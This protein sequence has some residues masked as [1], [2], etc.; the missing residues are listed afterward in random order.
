MQK[1]K[2][3]ILF[4]L[5]HFFFLTHAQD[6][7]NFTQF[8][9]NP[10]SLN[11]SFAGIDGRGA[12]FLAYRKQWSGIE[13]SPTIANLS[14]HGPLKSSGLSMGVNVA[15][16]K[17]GILSNSGLLLTM[18]YSVS[19]GESKFI[20]FGLS[21]GGSWNTVDLAKL[22]SL[23]TD[24]ALVNLLNQ[25]ASITG[26][27]GISLHLKSFHIG[28]AIPNLFAPSYVSKDAF[29]VT[30]VKPF[31][32]IVV[33]AS[34][35]FYFANNK[36]VFE[37]YV[38]YRINNGLPSQY[39]AA[40]VL[41]LNHLVWLGGSYKQDFGISGF[42]GIKLNHSF[43]LGGSYSLKNSGIN[44][45]SFPS[46]E[47]QLSYLVGSSKS[48]TKSKSKT[49]PT[50]PHYSFVNTELPKKTPTQHYNEVIARGD[51]ALAAKHYE[52]AKS[53]YSEAQKLKPKESY[54]K[55]KI[56]EVNMLITYDGEIK[57]ADKELTSKSYEQAL[58]DYEAATKLNPKEQ[59]P[60]DK[61]AEIK[62]LLS[63]KGVEETE[64][65]YKEA[66]ARADKAM[67]SKNYEEAERAYQ[68]ALTYKPSENYPKTKIA[69]AEKSIEYLADIKKAD[70]EM[71]SK[72]FE[73]ALADY[74]AASLLNPNE[75]YPKD[76][77]AQIKAMMA[78]KPKEE[79]A[80]PNA[81]P[82][83]EWLKTKETEITNREETVKR[84]KHAQ[85]L[86]PGN[87]VI[88]GVFGSGP[89]A[90]NLARKLV[91]TGFNANYGYLTEK[92]LW[93]VHIFAGDDING[94][95]AERDKYRKMPIFK[96]AWLLTVQN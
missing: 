94:T 75:Q 73:Q 11:P 17:R 1:A 37:P 86:N 34:N 83:T 10:Y 84:G 78:A 77:I 20:R 69:E 22:Q 90:K 19:L 76:K 43:A 32:A 28:A 7:G 27:A 59:Y 31:E 49:A 63:N 72:S 65:K 12:L 3:L 66:I 67:A 89:N 56:A 8:F 71:T 29:T 2:Y 82:L 16:D 4:F 14:Y 55:T 96:N 91:D 92:K 36:H 85:E 40:G 61:I 42:G 87:Y 81:K 44:E 70:S 30:E 57:K 52:D 21:G 13:G 64:R 80:D 62:S 41:H 33:H 6:T 68:E 35:R 46:Y 24:P 26:N 9:F 45:L 25:N 95:R 53:A 48:K 88:I 60:K 93:Y 23:G 15:N 39:E 54:P 18:A 79:V 51:K 50:L 58:A 74:E 47:V 38:V 5:S